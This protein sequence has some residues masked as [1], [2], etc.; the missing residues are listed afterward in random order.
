MIFFK[1]HNGKRYIDKIKI[2]ESFSSTQPNLSKILRKLN[3]YKDGEDLPPIYID[4]D[5]YLVDGYCTYLIAKSLGIAHDV[6]VIEVKTKTKKRS[7]KQ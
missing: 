2:R 3:D 6:K 4:E 1:K 5:F 7:K